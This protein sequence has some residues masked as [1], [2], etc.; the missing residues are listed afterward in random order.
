MSYIREWF[1]AHGRDR[2][3]VVDD[4]FGGRIEIRQRN[5]IVWVGPSAKRVPELPA[6]RGKIA[7]PLGFRRDDAVHRQRSLAIARPLVG[8]E[9]ESPVTPVIQAP[10]VD[11]SS[12]RRPEL[13]ALEPVILFVPKGVDRREK[14]RG[15]EGVVAQKVECGAVQSVG[16]RPRD[17]VHDP[18]EVAPEF[19]AEVVGLDAEFLKRVRV[20]HGIGGVAVMVVVLPAVQDVVCRIG[21]P[22]VHGNRRHAGVRGSR[23]HVGPG[24][25]LNPRDE[26]HQLRGISAIQR[27]L[28][29]SFLVDDGLESRRH[30][31]DVDDSAGN[32][33]GLRSLAHGKRH[34]DPGDFV[35]LHPDAFGLELLEPSGL[36][37]Q[38]VYAR[39]YRA[40]PV[41]SRV[42]RHPSERSV[43]PEMGR[44]D[45]HSRSH[46]PRRI[47]HD[48][49]NGSGDI[50][51]ASMAGCAH[52]A[53]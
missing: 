21:P 42:I 35:D 48:S 15:I 53:Q 19:G 5:L 45:C 38:V 12:E 3:V 30:G 29:D 4:V 17:G 46:R 33:H 11:R 50:R 41:N 6:E 25:C 31:V 51:R 34:V 44:N 28:F 9:E 52:A 22:A 40:E 26:S 1:S 10:E 27:E 39:R 43:G 20:R 16:A 49:G 2:E 7:P 13:V 37:R 32:H 23:G 18:A 14:V 8:K 24:V 47:P 36:R